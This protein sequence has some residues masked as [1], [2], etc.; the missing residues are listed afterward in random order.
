MG[1]LLRNSIFRFLIA[2]IIIIIVI[3]IIVIIIIISNI[4]PGCSTRKWFSGRSCIRSNWNLEMQILC[5]SFISFSVAFPM[6]STISNI[7]YLCNIVAVTVIQSSSFLPTDFFLTTQS[8]VFELE[9][10]LFQAK[11]CSCKSFK[12]ACCFY[13]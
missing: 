6:I 4:Y 9:C 2:I 11:N 10:S 3:I 1:D 7:R 5:F 13:E 8:A 12:S